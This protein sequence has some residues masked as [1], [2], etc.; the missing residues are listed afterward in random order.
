MAKQNDDRPVII[1]QHGTL[2]VRIDTVAEDFRRLG[3]KKRPAKK[4]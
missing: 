4:Q 2:Y 1:A 3:M